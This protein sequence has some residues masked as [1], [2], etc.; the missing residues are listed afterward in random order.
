MTQDRLPFQAHSATSLAAAENMQSAACRQ[1]TSV[2]LEFL[3]AGEKGLTDEECQLNLG[4]AGSSQ[5]PRRCELVSKGLLKD[6]GRTRR[7]ISGS[8]ATV[9][10][11]A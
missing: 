5:R 7:T 10:S 11:M 2:L 3:K 8:Q 1:R 6:S 9:W 4:L